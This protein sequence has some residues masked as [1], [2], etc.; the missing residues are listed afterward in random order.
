MTEI[1]TQCL[2]FYMNANS[3]LP[4]TWGVLGPQWENWLLFENSAQLCGVLDKIYTFGIQ[5]GMYGTCICYCFIMYT[6][7]KNFS[8]VQCLRHMKMVLWKVALSGRVKLLLSFFNPLIHVPALS[9]VFKDKGSH[10]LASH[11][12]G[13]LKQSMGCLSPQL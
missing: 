7:L 2:I 13:I 5:T 10:W 11:D 6:Q 12:I 4:T 3:L 9:P 1:F 8:K